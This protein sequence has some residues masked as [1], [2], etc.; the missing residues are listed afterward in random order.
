[1]RRSTPPIRGILFDPAG[2]RGLGR[3]RESRRSE[4]G[5]N[6]VDRDGVSAGGADVETEQ[7]H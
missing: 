2:S 1:M 4:D 7:H 3:I 6:L 5:P